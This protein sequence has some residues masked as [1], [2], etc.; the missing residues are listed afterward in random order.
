[1]HQLWSARTF[2]S[3]AIRCLT[4]PPTEERGFYIV[5][6]PLKNKYICSEYKNV[7]SAYHTHSLRIIFLLFYP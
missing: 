1:M 3:L 7:H 5:S 6:N 4:I 2:H